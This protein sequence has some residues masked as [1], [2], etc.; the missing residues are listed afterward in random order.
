MHRRLPKATQADRYARALANGF[1]ISLLLAVTFSTSFVD[2]L[3]SFLLYMI[4]LT[5]AAVPALQRGKTAPASTPG[6][7]DH[8]VKALI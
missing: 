4:L 5:A 8:G 1:G 6:S 2:Q 3:M 7:S